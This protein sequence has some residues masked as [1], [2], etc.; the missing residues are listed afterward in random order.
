MFDEIDSINFGIYSSEEI[1][2]LAVCEIDSAKL[3]NEGYNHNT[4]YD[5]RLGVLENNK[6]CDTCGKDAWNCVS[7][8]G[9]ISLN[10]PIINPMFTKYVV[11]FLKCF[12]IKCFKILI[13]NEQVEF[14]GWKNI[15]NMKRLN[16]IVEKIEK[17]N[18]CNNCQ[19]Q[20]PAIKYS[21]LD[22][23]FSMS[24]KHKKEKIT[25]ELSVSDIQRTFENATCEDI[26]TLGF[27]PTMLHPKNFVMT[28]FPVLPIAVRPYTMFGT[29]CNDDDLSYQLSEIIKA[30]NHLKKSNNVLE[31]QKYLQC[32]YFKISTFYNNTNNRAKYQTNGKAIKGLKERLTGKEGIVRNVLIAKRC[33]Q[34]A[35]TVIGP[36]STLKMNQV[37]IPT[38]V[39]SNLTTSVRVNNFNINNLNKLLDEGKINNVITTMNNDNN[40]LEKHCLT[41]DNKDNI[42]KLLELGKVNY[43][44][45][46]DKRKI[47]CK[48]NTKNIINFIKKHNNPHLIIDYVITDFSTTNIHVKNYTNYRGTVLHHGDIIIRNN[49]EIEVKNEKETLQPGDK[50][51][52]NNKII[53]DI[54]Y[55]I[56]H[57]KYKLYIGD[58]CEKQLMNKDIVLINRQPTLFEGG[59]QAAEVVVSEGKTIRFNLALCKQFNADFDG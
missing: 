47:Q 26:K 5:T 38:I 53:N 13:T 1:K 31:T 22:N 37:A 42:I 40:K 33:E 35:R 34:T 39:A 6:I 45:T 55:P 52:R 19:Q 41:T 46:K 9:F 2:Q 20:Q 16:K 15:Y 56:E 18:I 28:V 21:A 14:Y 10:E 11:S 3:I 51:K 24:Y 57:R 48:S 36:E 43:I 12:C 27:D 17:T 44:V 30:N 54:K 23:I 25:V 59:M 29:V 7:H 4:V 58:I 32:L 50:L 8:F 49:I